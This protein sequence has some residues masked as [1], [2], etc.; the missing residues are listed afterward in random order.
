MDRNRF[1]FAITFAPWAAPLLHVI[2]DTLRGCITNLAEAAVIGSVVLAFSYVGALFF[3]VPIVWVLQRSGNLNFWSL[4]LSG[5][6]AGIAFFWLSDWVISGF[7]R[8][9][10]YP[11]FLAVAWASGLGL[12]VAITFGILARVH[13]SV[14]GSEDA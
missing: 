11:G 4:A 7:Q 6:L 14:G 3:G 9:N 1:L 12:S 2:A 10:F 5:I 13:R 8:P